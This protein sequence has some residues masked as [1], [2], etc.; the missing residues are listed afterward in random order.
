MTNGADS[1]SSDLLTP[2]NAEELEETA[3]DRPDEFVRLSPGKISD[4]AS[5]RLE[6]QRSLCTVIA[7]LGEQESGK[8]TFLSGLYQRFA[9]G[10]TKTTLFAGSK[11]LVSFEE[12]CHSARLASQNPEH[13][14]QRTRLGFEIY[15][16]D[17]MER[18]SGQ[19][20]NLLFIDVS[21]E[22]LAELRDRA[23]Y[24]EKLTVLERADHIIYLIDGCEV[25]ASERRHNLLEKVRV[26]IS[27]LRECGLLIGQPRITL[28]L[29][30]SDM[31]VADDEH[32]TRFIERIKAEAARFFQT[33][34]TF[35]AMNSLE[36]FNCQVPAPE[37][38]QI[39]EDFLH[40][41][42]PI[43]LDL[44]EPPALRPSHSI[45]RFRR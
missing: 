37:A 12:L 31:V 22:S 36:L 34:M 21:G 17:V 20:R 44:T 19:R 8:T 35:V 24:S 32:T 14:M 15:H 42:F 10:V 18:A 3:S 33:P 11:T 1:N 4:V 39:L 25:A 16:L 27:R 41:N 43:Q 45:D 30:K 40:P 7:I 9:K 2:D 23:S 26:G 5:A 38:E 13:Q 6:S 29:N 28:V